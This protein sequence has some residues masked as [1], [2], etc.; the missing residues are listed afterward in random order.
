MVQD[1]MSAYFFMSAHFFMSTHFHNIYSFDG[2]LLFCR[3]PN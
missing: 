3:V 1:F 2:Y